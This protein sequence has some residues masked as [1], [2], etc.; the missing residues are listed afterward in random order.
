[1]PTRAKMTIMSMYNYDDTLFENLQIPAAIPDKNIPAADRA[2]AIAK[3]LL[4]CAEY[5]VM[6]P[7]I[8]FM[9]FAIANWSLVNAKKWEKLWYTEN[10][11]YDPIANVDAEEK[12]THNLKYARD[13][14]YTIND[15]GKY[16]GFNSSNM[17]D[18]TNQNAANRDAG[19]T[20]DTGTIAKERHGNIGVTS[21][22][23]LIREDRE[24]SDFSL[25]QVIA[26]DFKK[27]FCVL[28]Y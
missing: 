20:D 14:N 12:E 28:V 15:T 8:D 21:T 7:D 4:D 10:I 24:I 25:Y 19:Y 16:S 3:I 18:V 13:L 23:T 26:D 17:R 27:S 22:Q 6:Y 11:S 1:M 5:E 2:V 9:K